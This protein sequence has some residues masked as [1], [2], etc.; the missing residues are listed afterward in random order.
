MPR[1]IP[2]TI[3]APRFAKSLASIAAADSP[4]SEQAREPMTAIYGAP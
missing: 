1:A 3:T 2:L 4:Y